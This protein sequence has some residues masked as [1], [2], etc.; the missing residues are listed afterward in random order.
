M[1]KL[2]DINELSFA[3]AS[4]IV[5]VVVMGN[6]RGSFGDNS[7][8][9]TIGLAVI[10]LLLTAFILT[11]RLTEKYGF[12]KVAEAKR[13]LYFIPF[14]LLCTVNFWFGIRLH[15]SMP[16]QIIAAVNLGLAGYIEEVI[17]RGL[18]FRAIEKENVRRAVVISAVTFGVGHIVNLLT[19]GATLETLLQVAYAIAIG[20][21]FVLAFLKSGSLIPCIA[22]HCVINISSVFSNNLLPEQTARLYDYCGTVFIIVVAAFYSIYLL[23]PDHRKG[24]DQGTSE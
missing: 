1:K 3:I 6:L 21:S 11:N 19:G 24:S 22:A 16:G 9:A 15:Y 20:F 5:Y 7:L 13:Y 4:I 2:Y 10:A 23:K 14:V 12:T 8:Y 17:F 18:L